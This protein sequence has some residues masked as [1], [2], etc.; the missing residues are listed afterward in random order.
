MVETYGTGLVSE[1]KLERI[2]RDIFPLR[3]LEIIEYLRLRR[4]IYEQTAAY[5]HFGRREP[6][7]TW[8]LTNRADEIRGAA[9]L[10]GEA[11]V[12]EKAAVRR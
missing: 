2:V 9:G 10:S 7:F 6:D 1:E 5:G 4:P 8:E 11:L 3:P 12:G